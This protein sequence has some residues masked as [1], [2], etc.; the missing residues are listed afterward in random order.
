MLVDNSRPKRR[1]AVVGTFHGPRPSQRTLLSR[2]SGRHTD[3]ARYTLNHGKTSGEWNLATRG[4]RTT[5]LGIIVVL[6]AMF[7]GCLQSS[8]RNSGSWLASD[9]NSSPIAVGKADPELETPES[10][11]LERG[12]LVVHTNFYLPPTHPM[13]EDLVALRSDLLKLLRCEPGTEPIQ[14]YLYRS[15]QDLARIVKQ[16]GDPILQRRAYFIQSADELKVYASWTYDVGTDL[17]HELTHGYLHSVRSS[18]PLWLDEGLAEYFEVARPELGRH[19]DHLAHLE[20]LRRAGQTDFRLERL[21]ALTDPAD[22]KQSDYALSWWWV[23]ALLS[24]PETAQ[25]LADYFQ[26]LPTDGQV[27]ETLSASL[28]TLERDKMLRE[29]QSGMTEQ[30]P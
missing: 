15:P 12:Q 17:R 18:I 20:N 1:C 2:N 9:S 25:I 30:R 19:S 23:S 27:S 8:V 22:F 6:A 26:K 10:F 14:V 11:R 7:S 16:T 28:P 5:R 4:G 21:E 29:I 3:G 24:K 13:L